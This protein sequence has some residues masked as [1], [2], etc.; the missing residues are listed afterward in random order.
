MISKNAVMRHAIV[1]ITVI[2][3]ANMCAPKGDTIWPPIF[4]V[5]ALEHACLLFDLH[6]GFA[7]LD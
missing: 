1:L 5:S 6:G 7:C 4:T 2:I 3:S